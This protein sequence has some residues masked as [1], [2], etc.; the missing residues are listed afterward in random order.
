MSKKYDI[1][2]GS[3]D[4]S[5]RITD[6]YLSKVVKWANSVFPEGYTLIFGKGY[7]NGNS[8]DCLML[9]VLVNR[10]IDVIQCLNRLKM[11]LDQ[12]SILFSKYK[13]ETK[14]V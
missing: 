14:V 4:G 5:H 9:D 12:N 8:E 2:I 3:D 1:Y 6:G 10:E 13:V 7:W 11:E